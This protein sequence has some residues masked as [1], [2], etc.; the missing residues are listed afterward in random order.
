MASS[1]LTVTNGQF[2]VGTSVAAY[3]RKNRQQGAPNGTVLATAAVS[4]SSTLTFTGL[5]DDAEY[6]AYALVNSQHRYQ[7]FSTRPAAAS[8]TVTD[9]AVIK[10]APLN[11]Q[12]PEYGA[13]GDGVSVDTAAFTTAAAALPAKGGLI[14]APSGEYI[15]NDW[16]PPAGKMVTVVGDGKGGTSD[17]FG[18][19]LK[20]TTAGVPI[21]RA[22]GTTWATPGRSQVALQH[23]ELDGAGLAGPVL[24]HDRA[25]HVNHKSLR[26]ARSGEELAVFTQLFDSYME[27]VIFE[28]GALLA[29]KPAV[30]FDA[31]TGDGSQGGSATVHINGAIFQGNGFTDLKLTGIPGEV[32]P[33]VGVQFTNLHME[34]GL[35]AGSPYIDLDYA[36]LCSF[37]GVTL[38]TGGVRNVPFI[39][40]LGTSAGSRANRIIGIT[41][42]AG[43]A[44][45]YGIDHGVGALLVAGV[46]TCGTGLTTGILRVRNTVGPLDSSFD[47]GLAI[48]NVAR[49]TRIKD[50]RA[51]ATVAS[52]ATMGM[53]AGR[54][55]QV[56]GGAAITSITPTYPGDVVTL[57]FTSTATLTDGS[58]LKLSSTLVATPDDA[59][60]L[61]CDGTNWY[62]TGRSVN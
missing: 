52:T 51:M 26:V 59:I 43:L 54:V 46:N 48:T 50:E 55:V 42:D 28:A 56:T 19:R 4:A 45:T 15:V 24:I 34:G 11:V 62:E 33:T 31:H 32:A 6:T 20:R 22:V 9:V 21:V 57:V 61:V 41:I 7:D 18:T 10:E 44:V 29:T 3:S 17:I 38:S 40:Q 2:P 5:V 23:L 35:N 13:K 12:Y 39:Q 16:Q 30:T 49:A 37:I 60:T 58:N 8:S 27:D 14:Y 25:S 53:V 47:P 36:Q 1:V